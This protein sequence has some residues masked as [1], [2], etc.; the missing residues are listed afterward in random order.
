MQET[1]EQRK[2]NADQLAKLEPQ[3]KELKEVKDNE[4]FLKFLQA[5]YPNPALAAEKLANGIQKS[6]LAAIAAYHPD[7][8]QGKD[9]SLVLLYTEITKML[10]ARYSEYKPL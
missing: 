1:D 3:L 8:Q 5:K 6:L 2:Q 9:A 4:A 10:N 7:K